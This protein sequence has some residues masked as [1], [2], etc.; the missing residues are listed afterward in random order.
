MLVI[1]NE[2]TDTELELVESMVKLESEHLAQIAKQ[3]QKLT[4]A[5]NMRIKMEIDPSLIV[6]FTIRH[7]NGG[8][9]FINMSVV[10]EI[11]TEMDLGDIRLTYDFVSVCFL[12]IEFG[13]WKQIFCV[14]RLVL[15]YFYLGRR[16][17]EETWRER[18]GERE[19]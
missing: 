15:T 4:C 7:G 14:A 13:F 5:K 16:R 1:Y 9:K 19:S 10:E 3:V 2:I 11:T 6:G 8:L 12:K 17:E 18:E